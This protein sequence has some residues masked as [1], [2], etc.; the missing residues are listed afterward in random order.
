MTPTAFEM[1]SGSSPAGGVP[2][3]TVNSRFS[4]PAVNVNVATPWTPDPI[5]TVALWEPAGIT[6]PPTAMTM[7]GSL[8]VTVTGVLVATGEDT[9]RTPRD[10]WPPTPVN[11]R[12]SSAEAD[13]RTT[14]PTAFDET[15]GSRS[16]GGVPTTTVSCRVSDP[17]TN[18]NVATPWLPV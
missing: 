5:V 9:R 14:T 1:T 8:V 3:T 16:G 6:T 2:T 7:F 15:G 11:T 10:D 4:V 18:V 13:C 17:A 12:P